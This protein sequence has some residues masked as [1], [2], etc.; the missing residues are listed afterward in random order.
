MLI[1]NT[2]NLIVSQLSRRNALPSEID[3]GCVTEIPR[4][5]EASIAISTHNS[6][7]L[8]HS[9]YYLTTAFDT[10]QNDE[11]L[12]QSSLR[13]YQAVAKYAPS[14][15]Q[16]LN[17]PPIVITPPDESAEEI[18]RRMEAAIEAERGREA[19]WEAERSRETIWDALEAH[20]RGLLDYQAGRHEDAIR[21]YQDAIRSYRAALSVH[22]LLANVH[23]D[24]GAALYALGRLEEAATEYREAIRLKPSHSAAHNNLGVIYDD[25]GELDRAEAEYRQALESNPGFPDAWSNL[26]VSLHKKGRLEEA[27]RCY[28]KALEL[29]PQHQ[30]ARNNLS[31]AAQ[32]VLRRRLHS[33]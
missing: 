12:R 5:V 6:H 20:R 3:E 10:R 18:Q 2:E 14:M 17:R 4:I 8:W 33:R 25:Q 7:Y 30:D 32:Q 23:S 31:Q 15:V 28:K 26:G 19:V 21:S 16:F 1:Q 24:M 11:R 9:L 29:N 27:I 13:L 22:G